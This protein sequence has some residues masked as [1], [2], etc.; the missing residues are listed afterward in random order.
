M[1]RYVLSGVQLGCDDP[2][3]FSRP[4]RSFLMGAART[5]LVLLPGLDGTGDLFERVKRLLSNDCDVTVVRYP[6]DPQMG[7]D[8][9]VAFA[10]NAIGVRHVIILGESFSGPIAVRLAALLP[11]QVYGL[12][13]AATFLQSPWPPFIMRRAAGIDPRRAPRLAR[14]AFL[15]GRYRDAELSGKIDL[16][17]ANLPPELRA[18][19]I[20]AVAGV[21]VRAEFAR[22]SCPVL[23][24]HGTGDWVVPTRGMK[25]T[26]QSKPGAQLALFPAAH[27]L[28]QTSTVGAAEAILTFIKRIEHSL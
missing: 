27:M 7:Y 17:V 18:A 6:S 9:Y 14:D 10:K 23:G 16:I 26:L 24:L 3:T 11:E 1:V 15:M 5:Q 2:Y 4:S 28:L 12:I 25:A 21:D 19:R 22:V 13:L 20:C 8:D